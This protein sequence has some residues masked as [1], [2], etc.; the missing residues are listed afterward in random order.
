MPERAAV[1]PIHTLPAITTISAAQVALITFMVSSLVDIGKNI[2]MIIQQQATDTTSVVT[3]NR[4]VYKPNELKRKKIFIARSYCLS[5]LADSA[6]S[7]LF[8]PLITHVMLC[9]S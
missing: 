1:V 2:I 3:L 8:S 5:L 6:L 7:L 9:W 4:F